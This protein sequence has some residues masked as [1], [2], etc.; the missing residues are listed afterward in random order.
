LRAVRSEEVIRQLTDDRRGF[1]CDLEPESRRMVVTFAAFPGRQ[2]VRHFAFFTM[3]AEI[4]VKAAFL[5]DHHE[6]W[7]H[8]GV[9]G[10]GDG[11]DAVAAFLSDLATKAEEVVMLGTSSG[12]YAAL[13]FASLVGCEAHA[14]SPQTFID[15]ELRELYGDRRF[16]PQFEGLGDDMDRRYADLNGVA[17][18]AEAPLNIYY[19]TDNLLDRLHAEHVADLD[20]VV[21]HGFDTDSHLLARHLRDTGWLIPFLERVS[22][23]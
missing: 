19:A 1:V 20:A 5:R 15:P 7:Y 2:P 6:A 14:F 11:V 16:R 22:L 18:T 17:A 21:L 12:A 10:I 3:L 4:D 8:R 13:L 23:G 9:V